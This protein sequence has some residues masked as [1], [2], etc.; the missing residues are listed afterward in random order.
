M[1]VTDI[2]LFPVIEFNI[3]KLKFKKVYQYGGK[4]SE[5]EIG[6]DV[7]IYYNPENY[8][9]YYIAGEDTPQTLSIVF[10]FFG[11]IF[12]FIAIFWIMLNT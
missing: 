10:T 5:Y 11:I 7:E 9:E 3:G 2:N 12:I 1:H 8:K 6:Q 4:K